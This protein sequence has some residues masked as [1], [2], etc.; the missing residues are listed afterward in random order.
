MTETT[1][2]AIRAKRALIALNRVY[3]M[4]G[5]QLGDEEYMTTFNAMIKVLE[6]LEV[7]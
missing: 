5:Y 4:I 6:R 1:K 7:E 2:A 3:L